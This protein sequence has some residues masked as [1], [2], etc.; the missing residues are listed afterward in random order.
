MCACRW[1]RRAAQPDHR[2][3]SSSPSRARRTRRRDHADAT[4]AARAKSSPPAAQALPPHKVPAAIR[5]VPALDVA[6]RRQAEPRAR[7]VTSSSPAAAAAS[8]SASRAGLPRPAIASSRWRARKATNLPRPC[9]TPNAAAGVLHLAVRS[10]RDRR[11]PGLV[12]GPAQ[13]IRADLRPR[14]QR[15]ARHRRRAGEHAQ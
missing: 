13:G 14:Q 15:R 5:F 11:D 2:R 12:Q 8:A 10:R 6:R 3:A 7:C 9:E 4:R 1:C